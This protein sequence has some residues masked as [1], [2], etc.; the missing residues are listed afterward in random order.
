MCMC[1]VM[2]YGLSSKEL[3]SD[4]ARVMVWRSVSVDGDTAVI[5][6]RSGPFGLCVCAQ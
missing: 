2:A 5:G 6:A 1:A 4:G 3:A